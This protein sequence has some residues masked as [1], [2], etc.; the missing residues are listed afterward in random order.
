MNFYEITPAPSGPESKGSDFSKYVRS[1]LLAVRSLWLHKLR[2]FLSV[3]GIIIGTAAVIILMAFGNGSMQDALDDIALRH[4]GDAPS[5]KK[6]GGYDRVDICAVN[7]L[8]GPSGL[9][10]SPRYEFFVDP[11]GSSDLAS[12][13]ASVDFPLFLDSLARHYSAEILTRMFAAPL[14]V[15]PTR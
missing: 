15:R 9:R 5:V 2:A 4:A 14:S 3:L 1:F 11:L 13:T 7:Q 10:K 8:S 12:G 6:L